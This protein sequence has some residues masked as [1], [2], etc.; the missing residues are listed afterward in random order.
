[1]IISPTDLKKMID[2]AL[3]KGHSVDLDLETGKLLIHAKGPSVQ[4][5]T[6]SDYD[7]IN[8]RRKK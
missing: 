8:M 1:M 7:L 3:E 2:A 5:T 6:L 4:N